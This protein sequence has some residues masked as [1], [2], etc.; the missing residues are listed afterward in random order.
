MNYGV[1]ILEDAILGGARAGNHSLFSSYVSPLKVVHRR[2]LSCYPTGSMNARISALTPIG[3]YVNRLS[4]YNQSEVGALYLAS[5]HRSCKRTFQREMTQQIVR[6]W[7]ADRI[8]PATSPPCIQFP[9]LFPYH[10]YITI[11]TFSP[12]RPEVFCLAGMAYLHLDRYPPYWNQG[13]PPCAI[14]ACVSHFSSLMII[15]QS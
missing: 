12:L 11:R 4:E 15:W 1:P 13:R 7:S 14:L 2:T 3:P 8:E 10:T 5:S 6:R 9:V